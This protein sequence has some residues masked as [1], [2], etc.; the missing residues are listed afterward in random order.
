MGWGRERPDDS[1]I[2]RMQYEVRRG[3]DDGATGVSTG[4]DYISQCFADTDELATV[5]AASSAA[6]GV[7]VTHVRYK[8]GTLAG[9]QRS[10]RDRPARQRAAARLAPQ[11]HQPA[12]TR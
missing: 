2:R 8:R 6:R 9:V 1:Q 10:G 12:R 5:I 7:F 11:G 3:M 4:M